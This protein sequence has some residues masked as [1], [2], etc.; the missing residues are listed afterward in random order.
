MLWRFT[1]KRKILEFSEEI[2]HG[3]T[4]DTEAQRR[5]KGVR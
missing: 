4:K 2:S 1:K 3:G 5:I